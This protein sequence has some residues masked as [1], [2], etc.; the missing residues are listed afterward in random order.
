MDVYQGSYMLEQLNMMYGIAGNKKS[1]TL[2]RGVGS[3]SVTFFQKD[4]LC[5]CYRLKNS[6]N[7]YKDAL[8]FYSIGKLLMEFLPNVPETTRV[9]VMIFMVFVRCSSILGNT[10]D[11]KA[12][13]TTILWY[14]SNPL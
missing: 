6:G 5:C 3:S 8:I 12:R 7:S 9:A 4:S 13:V 14:F 1:N 10:L 11:Y 2:P